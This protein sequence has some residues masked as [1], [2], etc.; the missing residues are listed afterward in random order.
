M[1]NAWTKSRFAEKLGLRYAIVQAPMAGGMC[2]PALV[3]AVSNAGALG[4]FAGALLAPDA[5]RAGIREIRSL[6]NKP[7]NVNLFA[8]SD[9]VVDQAA[10]ARSIAALKPWRDSLGL[11]PP[12]L[13]NRFAESQADQ[14]KVVL[15]E[16]VPVFSFAFGMA[17]PDALAAFRAAGTL[18]IGTAT[19]VTEAKALEAAGVDVVCAQGSEAGGHRG[20]FIGDFDDA[21]IGTMA[22]VPQIAAAVKIPVLAAGGIMNGGGIAAALALGAA[23]AQLGTAFLLC[24]EANLPKAHALAMALVAKRGTRLTRAYTGRPARGVANRFMR[25]MELAARGFPPYP[26]QRALTRDILERARALGRDDIPFYWCGQGAALARAL[27]AATLVE[28]LANE[29][30]A[31]LA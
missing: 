26:I 14:I 4:S 21:L 5:I 18:V 1:T 19:T 10:I 3:A 29:T 11:D 22:L 12:P 9:P 16:R 30:A 15:E 28:A 27:P 20:T 17:P 25:D 24:P 6:T 7:F 13:P 31:A 2:P 23:G 8:F